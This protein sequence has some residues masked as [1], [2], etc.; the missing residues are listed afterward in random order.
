MQKESLLWASHFVEAFFNSPDSYIH[1]TA[2]VDPRVKLGS[3]AK[4]GPFCTLIGDITIGKNTRLYGHVSVGFPAQS[5]GTKDNTGTIVIGDDCEIR[6]FVTIHGSKYPAGQT[7]IGN[8]CYL[9][10]YCHVSHDVT[11]EDNVTLINSVNLGG[12]T[13][14]EKNG[15]MMAN[16][17]THQFCRVGTFTALAPFGGIR[18]DLPPFCLFS[19]QPAQ[20]SGL[21]ATGLK[22][23]GFSNE[24]INAL[25]HVTKLFFQDKILLGDIK[26][27]AQAEP[28]WGSD[29]AVQRFI[30]FIEKSDRGVSRRNINDKKD[31]QHSPTF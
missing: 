13:Y 3:G 15:F 8:N 4:I 20:F 29:Q 23:A 10:N 17:A 31:T 11:L 25:K 16:A 19:G 12:H 22:R 9:M 18:Q 30:A 28:V 1:P 24:S 27:L 5:R 21:N 7:I 2:I 6:E 14:I 26:A